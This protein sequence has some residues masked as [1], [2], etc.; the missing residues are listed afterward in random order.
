MRVFIVV[1]GTANVAEAEAV[2]RKIDMTV[3]AES[4]NFTETYCEAPIT[5]LPKIR[6]WYAEDAGWGGTFPAGSCLWFAE[7]D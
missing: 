3:T 5:E 1:K 7:R 4:S 2:R 6:E